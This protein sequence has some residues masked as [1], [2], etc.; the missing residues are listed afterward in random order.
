MFTAETWPIAANMIAFGNA[1]PG[2]GHIRDASAT[3][4]AKQL[5]QVKRLGM[6]FIDPTDA[7]VPLAELSE[8]RLEEFLTVLS[9]EGLAIPSISMTRR[10]I[11]DERHGEKHLA[12][13]RRLIDLAPR[14]GATIVNLGF[15]QALTPEQEE[16]IWFWLAPGHVDTA[17]KRDLAIER[18]R[19][20]GDQARE[21]GIELSLEIY[22]DTYVGSPDE[23]VRFVKDVAHPAVGLNPDL[24]NLIR[25]HRPIEHFSAMFE[26]VLPH[27]NFWHI[28]NYTRDFDP[29]TGAYAT[30]PVP[31]KYGYINYRTIIERALE[32]GFTGPFCCEHYGSD[33]L[34]VIAENYHYIREVLDAALNP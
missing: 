31:L 8:P 20:L 17:K 1:A 22:E 30:A 11:V 12:E 14:V 28:K 34:G 7:W 15:M 24:G 23:A 25:L 29:K 19:G 5:R 26:K 21:R 10:S 27:T 16:A 3:V 9:D 2:G 13:A 32:L 33:S 6:D 4:W 18:L